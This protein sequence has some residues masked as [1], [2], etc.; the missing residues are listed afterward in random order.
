MQNDRLPG[1]VWPVLV[2]PFHEDRSIDEA[3]LDTLVEW[4]LA[5][6]V[7]GFFAVAMSA[8]VLCLDDSEKQQLATAILRRVDGRVPVVAGAY[9]T[10][11]T[12]R[13]VDMVKRMA[14]TGVAGVVLTTCQVV[15]AEASNAD[16]KRAT[17]AIIAG[18]DGIRLGLYEMPVP[19]H[20]LLS[21]DDMAWAASTGR[22]YFHKDTACRIG[23]IR[24]KIKAVAG[25]PLRFYNANTPTLLDSLR[26]GGDGY[27]GIGANY[28]PDLYVQLCAAAGEDGERADAVQRML[29]DMDA[30]LHHKYPA[31]A[32]VFL[33]MRGLPIKPV[34]RVMD[35]NLDSDDVRALEHLLESVRQATFRLGMPMQCAASG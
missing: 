10:G 8:E 11:P 21:A 31:A 4:Q 6:G 19:Y 24:E 33:G 23:P 16:W 29:T 20:R 27:S 25:S 7:A 32:K 30:L 12:Q 26:S 14:D 34:C 5:A 2:T 22:M 1:G 18:T 13:Q 17:E 35:N 28:L 15:P 9:V 3:A